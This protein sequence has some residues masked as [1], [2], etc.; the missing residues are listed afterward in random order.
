[1][2]NEHSISLSYTLTKDEY[3]DHLLYTASKT[4]SVIKKRR[5]NRL[6][7][8]VLY[9][10]IAIFGFFI[11][12]FAL[13]SSLLL[14]AILWYLLFPKWEN[15]LYVKQYSKYLD[16]QLQDNKGELI[17]LKF[18]RDYISKKRNGQ[19]FTIP[20]GQIRGW[21]E[22]SQAVYIGLLD[23]YTIIIPKKSTYQLKEIERIVTSNNENLPIHVVKDLDWKWE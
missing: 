16:K 14:L 2:K 9:L 13:F 11:E 22:T 19:S 5:N 23:N 18:N 12:N 6:I 17:E 20:Y 4:P 21:Y 7:L 8:P 3:L 1:M 10:S 15:K